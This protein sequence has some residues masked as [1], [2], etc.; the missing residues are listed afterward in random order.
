MN[1]AAAAAQATIDMW[2]AG[3]PESAATG[4][5]LRNIYGA[6]ECTVHQTVAVVHRRDTPRNSVGAPLRGYARVHIVTPPHDHEDVEAS[7]EDR[8]DDGDGAGGGGDRDGRREEEEEEGEEG[9]EEGE[10]GG[11]REKKQTTDAIAAEEAEEEGSAV[12]K[13]DDGVPDA[14][15]DVAEVPAGA[16]GEVVISGRGVARGYLHRDDLTRARY[17]V[18]RAWGRC[19]RTGDLGRWAVVGGS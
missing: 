7:V 5:V 10:E 14:L 6:T 17:F 13:T 8:D 9:E 12:T 11:I 2:G 3:A 15:S 1:A 4:V 16:A 18:H 19:Y